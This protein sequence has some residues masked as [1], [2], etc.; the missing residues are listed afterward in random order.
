MIAQGG[1]RGEPGDIG[2]YDQWLTWHHGTRLRHVPSYV[3]QDEDIAPSAEDVDW[4]D[5]ATL[6]ASLAIVAPSAQEMVGFFYARLFTGNPHLRALFPSDMDDQHDRLLAA[7]LAL[8]S[9]RREE[10]IDTLTQLGRDHRKYGVRAALFATVGGA[11]LESVRHFAGSA[12]NPA[13]EHAWLSRYQAAAA[14]MIA[15]AEDASDLPPFWFATVIGH[16]LTGSDLAILRIRP[17]HPYPYAAGQ[18]AT[19]E[20]PRLPRV[21]HPYAIA[22]PPRPDS[23]LEF[24]VRATGQGGLS[25]VLVND[26]AVG[27]TLRLGAPRIAPAVDPP[28]ETSATLSGIWSSLEPLPARNPAPNRSAAGLE[29]DPLA[30]VAHRLG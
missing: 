12:W 14:T 6:E 1:R 23:V 29:V 22:T 10:L 4:G 5:Q 30:G 7:L 20:S 26:T 24:H 17:R 8:V 21:W 3:A 13:V 11:L 16:E 18:I 19:I 2:T 9:A 25:D 27:D 28:L 15:A